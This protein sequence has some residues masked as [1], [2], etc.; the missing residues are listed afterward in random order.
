MSPPII[1]AWRLDSALFVAAALAAM[2]AS[3][4]VI[5]RKHAVHSHHPLTLLFIT[6]II[7]AG[8]L[9]TEASDHRER[10]QIRKLVSGLAPT[11]A[12]ELSALGHAAITLDTPAD[13][14][15]YLEMIERE[16]AW[17][18][19]NPQVSDIYTY[20][21]APD[22]RIVF[23][24]DS[25]TDYNHD[26]VYSGEN[27][28]RTPIGYPYKTANDKNDRALAGEAIFD[29][30]IIADEWDVSI[31]FDQPMYD[32]NGKVEA[33]LGVDFP[34]RTPF[35]AGLRKPIDWFLNHRHEA[36]L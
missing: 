26:G 28:Q 11:F 3:L 32:A 13:D 1:L 16:K 4:I 19:I 9:W 12:H 23:I 8:L 31:S 35:E 30:E 18:R 27:E 29:T 22:G 5:R 7:A 25:E 17:L 2:A 36:R 15:R 10:N 20:R 33:V 6:A 21:R 24:V 14:P 34:A